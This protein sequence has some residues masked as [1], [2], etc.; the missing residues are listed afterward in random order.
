[1]AVP[2]KAKL[3]VRSFQPS[4][5]DEYAFVQHKDCA[6][7]TLRCESVVCRTLSIRHFQPKHEKNFKDEA[8]N[9]EPN[10][11][12]RGPES[13]AVSLLTSILYIISEFVVSCRAIFDFV[14]RSNIVGK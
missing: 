12:Y 5:R 14:L 7:C 2:K 4:W 6:V 1:M 11:P 10:R 3:D 8:D 9:A 13:K